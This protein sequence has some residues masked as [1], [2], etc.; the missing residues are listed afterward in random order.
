MD[1]AIHDAVSQVVGKTLVDC[2]PLQKT[3]GFSPALRLLARFA[4]GTTA[5]VK[6]ATNSS[7]AEWLRTEA[8]VYQHL[9]KRDFLPYV[10]GIADSS[11]VTLLVLEDLSAARWPAPWYAGDIPRV[12][13]AMEQIHELAS[14]FPPGF[15]PR[16]EDQRPDLISWEKVGADPESLLSL[17]LCSR[18][19][20]ENALPT[21]ISADQ[22]VVLDGTDLVHQDIRGDNLCFTEDGRLVIVDWNWVCIGNGKMDIACWLPSLHNEGGPLPEEILPNEPE[23]ASLLAGFWAARAGTPPFDFPGAERLRAFQRL[24][25]TVALPWAVRSLG[26]PPLD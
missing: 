13:A 8:I 19:W 14:F 16:Q 22:N 6:A 5:F 11:D 18:T 3:G 1:S 20:L 10:F 15:L 24:Q 12:L 9:G 17:G 2:Q 23:L 26:L 21:L 25:L 4:D 7:T